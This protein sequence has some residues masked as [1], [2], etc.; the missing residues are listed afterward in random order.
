MELD[1]SL[2]GG[3]AGL[4]TVVVAGEEVAAGTGNEGAVGPEEHTESLFA[5]E[6]SELDFSSGTLSLVLAAAVSSS[7]TSVCK[8]L[9]ELSLLLSGLL[10]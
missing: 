2:V 9:D 1:A 8:S 7:F 5:F 10:S 4:E 3:T 6:S